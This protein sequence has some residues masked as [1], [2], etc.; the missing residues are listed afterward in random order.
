MFAKPSNV[1]H[2]DHLAALWTVV[3][4]DAARVMRTILVGVLRVRIVLVHGQLFESVEDGVAAMAVK[5][6]R[7]ISSCFGRWSEKETFLFRTPGL[8]SSLLEKMLN[9]VSTVYP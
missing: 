1:L 5:L 8:I 9:R 6:S 2:S 3:L 4:G 7:V